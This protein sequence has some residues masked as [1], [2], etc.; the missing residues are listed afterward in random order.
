[1][2]IRIARILW[3]VAS[4]L[5]V[6]DWLVPVSNGFTRLLGLALFLAVWFGPVG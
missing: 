6:A 3:L 1:M 5:W 4:V 2:A